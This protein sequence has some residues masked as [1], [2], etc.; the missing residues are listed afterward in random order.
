MS[1]KWQLFYEQFFSKQFG[2]DGKLWQLPKERKEMNE[3]KVLPWI[4]EK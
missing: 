3:E 2:E 1:G 4:K